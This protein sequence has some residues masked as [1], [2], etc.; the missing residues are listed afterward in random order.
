MLLDS[1]FPL[2]KYSPLTLVSLGVIGLVLLAVTYF[3][4]VRIILVHPNYG[5]VTAIVQGFW[6]LA[7]GLATIGSF[8]LAAHN[9]TSST[10][11]NSGPATGFSIQG[12]NHDIDVY[13]NVG[14][15]DE[16]EGG[17]RRRREEDESEENPSG[18][19]SSET[20]DEEVVDRR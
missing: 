2:R 4:K 13:L 12:E 17:D 8:L 10:E 19:S 18:E 1:D 6:R 9:H 16:A 11:S 14:E 15:D 7:V 5:D 3:V 20:G